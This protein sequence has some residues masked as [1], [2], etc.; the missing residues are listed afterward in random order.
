[1]NK[2][3]GYKQIHTILVKEGFDIGKSHS[4][5]YSMIKNLKKREKILSQKTIVELGKI[6]VKLLNQ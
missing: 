6:E 1:M 3:L 5:V 2:G 4:C